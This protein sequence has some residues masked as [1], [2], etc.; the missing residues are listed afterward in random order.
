MMNNYHSINIWTHTYQEITIVQV[1]E[2]V[3]MNVRKCT[4][5]KKLRDKHAWTTS[6]TPNP[7]ETNLFESIG[8]HHLTTY[9]T[10]DTP[11]LQ[12]IGNFSLNC[13]NEY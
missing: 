9:K 11:T 7:G 4:K 3:G 13:K 8:C 2:T 1:S 5:W 6:K 10:T 12:L